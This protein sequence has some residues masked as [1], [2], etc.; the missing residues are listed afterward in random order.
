V[1]NG[2]SE[3]SGVWRATWLGQAGVRLETDTACVVVD[4]W[5]SPHDDRLVPPAPLELA[6]DGV[7]WLLVTHE[8]LDHL[9]LPLLPALLERS[10]G[11][12]VVLPASLVELVEDVVPASQLVPVQAPDTVDLGGLELTVVPAIHGVSVED[13]YGDGSAIGGRPRFVGYVLGGPAGVYHAGDTIVTGELGGALEPLAI[14]VAFLPVNGRDTE[15]EARGI[16][17]NMNA[18]EAVDLA[19]AIGARRLVPIHWDGFAG[20]TVDPESVVDAAGGRI[21]VF[22]PSRFETFDVAAE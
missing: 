11:V 14:D 6:A 8:H 9:D 4:P 2:G 5:V 7:D 21:D 15:R 20:N 13:A 12:R 18:A 22:V 3:A 17:G 1:S 16:V 19:L 10:P